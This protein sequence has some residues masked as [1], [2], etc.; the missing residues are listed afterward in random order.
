MK[1][2]ETMI[3]KVYLSLHFHWLMRYF[4]IWINIINIVICDSYA[5]PHHHVSV[6]VQ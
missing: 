4:E 3:Y 1:V 6:A 5:T 2:N